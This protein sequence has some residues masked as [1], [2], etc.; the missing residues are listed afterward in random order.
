MQHS[1]CI[2]DVLDVHVHYGWIHFSHCRTQQFV[3]SVRVMQFPRVISFIV[4]AV[5]GREKRCRDRVLI[6]IVSALFAYCCAY[7][8]LSLPLLHFSRLVLQQS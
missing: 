5:K 8:F 6:V 3:S 1:K 7:L 4:A 2:K